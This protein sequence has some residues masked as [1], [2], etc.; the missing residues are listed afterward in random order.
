VRLIAEHILGRDP[1]VDWQVDVISRLIVDAHAVVA[2]FRRRFETP[3]VDGVANHLPRLQRGH[4]RATFSDQ[5]VFVEIDAVV[6]VVVIVRMLAAWSGRCWF[7]CSGRGSRW[8][9]RS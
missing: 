9:L 7:Y 2:H 8:K 5:I 6:D 4:L 3:V 1:A